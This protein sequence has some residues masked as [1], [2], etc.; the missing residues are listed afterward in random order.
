MWTHSV[1]ANVDD[2]ADTGA[3]DSVGREEA[4]V[5]GLQRVLEKRGLISLQ[6]V[7]IIGTTILAMY[8]KF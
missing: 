1:V 3:L 2:H 5:L 4:N 7:K 6:A 8:T